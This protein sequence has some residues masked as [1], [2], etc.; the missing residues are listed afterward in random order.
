MMTG[1][2]MA[3]G[4]YYC[5]RAAYCLHHQGDTLLLSVLHPDGGGCLDG[6]EGNLHQC[7]IVVARRNVRDM[8][9]PVRV[10]FAHAGS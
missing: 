7:C 10:F 3:G 8:N 1:M 6:Y 4:Y 5:F 9:A 2:K